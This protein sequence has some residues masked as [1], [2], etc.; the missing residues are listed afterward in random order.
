MWSVVHHHLHAQTQ[1]AQNSHWQPAVPF[2]SLKLWCWWRHQENDILLVCTHSSLK[3]FQLLFALKKKKH[4]YTV[5][6]FIFCG[7][8]AYAMWVYHTHHNQCNKCN[9]D[10]IPLFEGTEQG[11]KWCSFP[12]AWK[13]SFALHLLDVKLAEHPQIPKATY[14]EVKNPHELHSLVT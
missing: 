5:K 7:T 8:L 14:S 13:E 12:C 11:I 2:K 10:L 9:Q 3:A 1:T 6:A 4:L